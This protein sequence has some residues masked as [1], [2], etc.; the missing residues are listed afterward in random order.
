[1]HEGQLDG[2]VIR[3]G[4]CVESLQQHAWHESKPA[5]PAPHPFQHPLLASQLDVG[6]GARGLLGLQL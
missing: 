4:A 1:M 5:P 6:F 3:W 2:N